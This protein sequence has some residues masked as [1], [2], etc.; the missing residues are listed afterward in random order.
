M[1]RL[2]RKL[3]IWR[4]L[5]IVVVISA[6][7]Y[8]NHNH[9]RRPLENSLKI[10]ADL[11]GPTR[12]DE[13][14]QKQ[15]SQEPPSYTSR[16]PSSPLPSLPSPF[17]SPDGLEAMPA[18]FIRATKGDIAAARERWNDTL[19]WREETGM[20]I[21]LDNPHPNLALIKKNYPHYF[22]LRGKNNECCYY[23]KPPKINLK[24]LR[25]AGIQL[26]ELVRHYA[27]CCE[28]MWKKIETSEDGQSI[29]VIDLDGIRLRDFVGEV[30]DFVKRASLFCTKHYPERSGSI[31]VINVPTWFSVI[32]A[33]VKPMLDDETKKKII[34]LGHKK[35]IITK[36]L[37][38]KISIENI[39]SEYGGCSMP[40]GF[41]PEEQ[42]F[43]SHFEILADSK[44]INQ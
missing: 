15:S 42:G 24:A 39:P 7:D 27:L 22:H 32:W 12:R 35:G 16:C 26:D 40:L 44:K 13:I 41:S 5:T 36:A 28:Y 14:H 10:G 23:E 18:S 4:I 30:V 31:Y 33:V 34:I 37:I 1:T 3:T 2:S 43:T 29:Y 25:K 19:R 38:E 6:S 21:I 8:S 11:N 9:A 17:L 20:D